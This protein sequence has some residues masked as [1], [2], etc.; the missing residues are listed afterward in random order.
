MSE[1]FSAGV[2]ILLQ[3]METHPEEFCCEVE[4]R[5]GIIGAM[6][7][8]NDVIT[9]VLQVKNKESI[10]GYATYLNEAEVDALFE[11]YKKIRRKDFDAHVME[12]VLNPEPKLSS[13][14]NNA[15]AKMT[16]MQM[17][18]AQQYSGYTNLAQA[19]HISAH[20]QATGQFG[21]E[22]ISKITK[23]LGFK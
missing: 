21:Q 16:A 7:K 10:R 18:G 4:T 15:R 20:Q 6:P 3:R 11:G 14:D 12:A 22:L 2:N 19:Q 5:N 8:W 17:Q 23:G 13:N 1:E 9:S